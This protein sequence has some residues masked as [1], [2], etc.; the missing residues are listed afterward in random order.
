MLHKQD[1]VIFTSQNPPLTF[2][3]SICFTKWGSSFSKR[4]CTLSARSTT[5]YWVSRSSYRSPNVLLFFAMLLYIHSTQISI[6]FTFKQ[7][8]MKIGQEI[9]T[10]PFLFFGTIWCLFGI[11]EI[12]ISSSFTIERNRNIFYIC[13]FMYPLCFSFDL[14]VNIYHHLCALTIAQSCAIIVAQSCHILAQSCQ[15]FMF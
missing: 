1:G 2:D 3:L 5:E 13:L 15:L 7:I 9:D 14:R 4:S 12:I 10:S 11:L 6:S 8:N